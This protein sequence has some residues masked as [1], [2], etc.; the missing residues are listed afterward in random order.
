MRD[1]YNNAKR[2]TYQSFGAA[3]HE[4]PLDAVSILIPYS[5]LRIPCFTEIIPSLLKTIP[6]YS[7]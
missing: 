7:A 1:G 4:S 6:C 3:V 2:N 5:D